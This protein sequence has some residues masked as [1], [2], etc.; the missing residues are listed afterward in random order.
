MCVLASND[1]ISATVLAEDVDI[2]GFLPFKLTTLRS[3][4]A[5]GGNGNSGGQRQEQ[6]QQ[7]QQQKQ[8]AEEDVSSSTTTQVRATS[9]AAHSRLLH[10]S[11]ELEANFAARR[12]GALW[13]D[14]DGKSACVF[15][16]AR[17]LA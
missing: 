16:H 8:Q 3:F 4:Y 7:Q 5:M 10:L 1:A 13:F 6:Q 9:A 12:G 17:S 11:A 14:R 15:A 2:Q